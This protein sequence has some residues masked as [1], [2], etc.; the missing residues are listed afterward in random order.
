MKPG[1]AKVIGWRALWFVTG[2]LIS[3]S[4][5]IGTF[6]LL[7]TKAGLPHQA[8][9]AGSLTLT[10]TVL[11]LWNYHVNF[12]TKSGFRECLVRYVIAVCLLALT[13]YSIVTPLMTAWKSYRYLLILL[14]QAPIGV[15]K[16]L[17]YHFWVYPHRDG[18]PEEPVEALT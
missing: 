9:Y 6:W 4:L 7:E 18:T 3:S 15:F 5:N 8:A 1:Q 16:F 12:R 13:N 10:T 17:L 14:V 2:G 11:S